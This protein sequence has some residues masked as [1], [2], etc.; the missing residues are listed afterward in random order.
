MYILHVQKKSWPGLWKCKQVC[1]G[2]LLSA[3]EVMGTLYY[4]FHE[5]NRHEQVLWKTPMT[6]E[7]CQVFMLY[8]DYDFNNDKLHLHKASI[9][10]HAHVN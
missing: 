6:F 1:V 9:F 8:V 4:F 2:K 7:T 5:S 3:R 10:V